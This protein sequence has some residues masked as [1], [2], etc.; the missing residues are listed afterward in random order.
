MKSPWTAYVVIFFVS[1]TMLDSKKTLNPCSTPPPKKVTK[2]TSVRV[3]NE[4]YLVSVILDGKQFM[5]RM[6]KSQNSRFCQKKIFL[7]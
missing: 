3:L 1:S 5:Q 7:E 6:R 2:I 4:Q